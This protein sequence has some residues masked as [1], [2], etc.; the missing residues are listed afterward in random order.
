MAPNPV[1]WCANSAKWRV[2]KSFLSKY[3]LIK[4]IKTASNSLVRRFWPGICVKCF[5]SFPQKN[6]SL[7]KTETKTKCLLFNFLMMKFTVIPKKSNLALGNLAKLVFWSISSFKNWKVNTFLRER[8]KTFYTY[9]R[10]KMVLVPYLV[11]DIGHNE[12]WI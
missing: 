5:L 11:W 9:S 12:I 4:S 3:R 8:E 6:L 2:H 10:P 1:H 7:E